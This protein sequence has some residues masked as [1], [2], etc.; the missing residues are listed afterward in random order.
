[1]MSLSESSSLSVFVSQDVG[2]ETIME[3]EKFHVWLV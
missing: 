3:R 2:V 1:M